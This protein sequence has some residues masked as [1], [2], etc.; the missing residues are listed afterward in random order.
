[1]NSNDKKYFLKEAAKR[2]FNL[3][4]A[5]VQEEE[6]VEE[7]EL[8]EVN[9]ETQVSEEVKAE[10]FATVNLVDG[11]VVTNMK[12]SDLEVGDELHVVTE[13][14]EHLIAPAGQ[15]VT[16]D[17]K[18]LEVDSQ[19]IIVSIEAIEEESEE[20]EEEVV[21]ES[22]EEEM[23]EEDEMDEEEA[24]EAEVSEEESEVA[25]LAQEVNELKEKL[26]ALESMFGEMEERMKDVYSST[27]ATESKTVSNQF[28]KQKKSPSLKANK[29]F[30]M[31][32]KNKQ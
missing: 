16:E 19:G 10:A 2:H 24:E 13:E 27:P 1:M 4:E 21:E 23:A 29:Y 26:T 31:A 5:P 14:G 12:D 7:V 25:V 20:S 8:S 11:T 17:G 28:S 9:N 3:V 18:A 22:Q 6:S 32:M 15:H 30:E